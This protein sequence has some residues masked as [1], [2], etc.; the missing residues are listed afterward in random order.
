MSIRTLIAAA[1]AAG[2]VSGVASASTLVF[3]DFSVDQFTENFDFQSENDWGD[4]SGSLL[5]RVLFGPKAQIGAGEMRF[6]SSNVSEAFLFY[7]NGGLGESGSLSLDG[8]SDFYFD[9]VTDASFIFS[10]NTAN[11]SSGQAF[12]TISGTA[13]ERVTLSFTDLFAGSGLNP[14]DGLQFLSFRSLVST[15]AFLTE[16]GLVQA[17]VIPL[18]GA[19]GMGLV[20][21]GLIALRRRR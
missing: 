10:V 9:F 7:Y 5:D 14:D 16:F 2:S 15:D 21:M 8:Y 3:D 6:E 17:T 13:G 19:A 11:G 4:P 18:P 1:I 20:G 12:T